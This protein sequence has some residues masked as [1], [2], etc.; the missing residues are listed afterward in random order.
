MR[1][2]EA[3]EHAI[4]INDDGLLLRRQRLNNF[5]KAVD[6]TRMCEAEEADIHN[7]ME[8]ELQKVLRGKRTILFEKLLREV[9]YPDARLLC[10]RAGLAFEWLQ[11]GSNSVY[12]MHCSSSSGC[13]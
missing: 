9:D 10:C 11:H 2:G 12:C 8:P 7:K 5:T 4:Q 6:V 3:L 13:Q 1:V